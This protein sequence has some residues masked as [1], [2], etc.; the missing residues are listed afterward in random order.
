MQLLTTLR[1]GRQLWGGVLLGVLIALLP[2]RA[3]AET[4]MHLSVLAPLSAASE[5]SVPPCHAAMVDHEGAMPDE[6]PSGCPLCALCHGADLYSGGACVAQDAAA[7][8][9]P[10]S[11]SIGHGPPALPLPERPPRA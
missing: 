8:S 1:Q 9:A 11:V 4:A 6:V 5:V 2:L 7:N 10:A 3:W